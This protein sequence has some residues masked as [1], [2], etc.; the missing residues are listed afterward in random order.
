MRGNG[1]RRDGTEDATAEAGGITTQ[2]LKHLDLLLVAPWSLDLT[3]SDELPISEPA[4]VQVANPVSFIAQ[5][6]LIHDLRKPDKRSQDL[7]YI[8][9]T[10][11]LFGAHLPELNRL[12]RDK[13]G[14]SLL[15]SDRKKIERLGQE[16]F[17]AVSDAIREASRKTSADRR[18]LPEEL[19]LRT[20]VGLGELLRTESDQS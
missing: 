7:L 8:H 15:P 13:V 12:W 10:L 3:P 1:L 5:K 19:R 6:L 9:D 18:L 4:R 20:E 16:L 11:E 17:A 2:N 14:P